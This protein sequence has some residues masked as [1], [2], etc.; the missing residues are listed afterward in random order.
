MNQPIP[1]GYVK[2]SE[3]IDAL[4]IF[5]T[6]N[7]LWAEANAVDTVIGRPDVLLTKIAKLRD[8]VGSAVNCYIPLA[9]AVPEGWKPIETAPMDGTV[10]LLHRWSTSFAGYYGG[11]DS[12][13]RINAPGLP[14]IGPLPTHWMPIPAS[15]KKPS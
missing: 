2:A 14:A 9:A 1:P 6:L 7:D 12:G 13:W 4:K 10:V 5:K 3:T 8:E 11:A 15:P